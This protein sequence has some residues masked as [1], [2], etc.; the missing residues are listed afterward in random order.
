MEARYPWVMDDLDLNL[1]DAW[2][3]VWERCKR[4]PTEARKRWRRTRGVMLG[5]PPR[6][7]CLTLRSSDTRLHP[8]NADFD[9]IEAWENREPHE[10]TLCGEG[11]RHLCAPVSIDWPGLKLKDAAKVLGKTVDAVRHWMPVRP[12]RARGKD[13]KCPPRWKEIIDPT[14][15]LAVRYEHPAHYG[16]QGGDVAVVWT[17]RSLDPGAPLGRCPHAIWGSMWQHIHEK[18]PDDYVLTV[19]RE[20]R[21]KRYGDGVRFRGWD[22]VCPGRVVNGVHR[23]C[24][25]RCRLLFGPLPV[26]TLGRAMGLGEGLIISEP[27]CVSPARED[28]QERR[29]DQSRRAETDQSVR[30]GS[31]RAGSLKL[32][33]AWFPG[34]DDALAGVRSFACRVCWG[35]ETTRLHDHVGWNH[36]VTYI[37]GGLLFGHEVERP[38]WVR[39]TKPRPWRRRAAGSEKETASAGLRMCR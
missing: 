16:H 39:Y 25:R 29:A 1:L 3:R 17:R 5:K 12:G 8:R 37:S 26:W 31:T 33:G 30:A 10:V 4:D 38:D 21:F 27:D 23:P 13:S 32:S 28:L 18:L 7:W 20:P 2:D 15:P 24:G 9:S 6:P 19:R 36:F 22:W 14:K 34:V 35:V 11:I